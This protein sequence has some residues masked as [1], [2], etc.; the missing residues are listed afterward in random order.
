V[1]SLGLSL[2]HFFGA[3]R[4]RGLDQEVQL[5]AVTWTLALEWA[6]DDVAILGGISLPLGWD[7]RGVVD[8]AASGTA[9]AGLQPWTAGIGITLSPF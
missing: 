5:W 1:P 8:G 7:K 6:N 2:S 3:D 4:D 9:D